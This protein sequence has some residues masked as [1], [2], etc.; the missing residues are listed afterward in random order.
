MLEVAWEEPGLSVPPRYSRGHRILV[1][2]QPLPTAS[3][4]RQRIPLDERRDQVGFIDTKHPGA[5]RDPSASATHL[6]HHYLALSPSARLGDAGLV[7]LA[8]MMARSES[9][10]ARPAL[11]RL[12]ERVASEEW[13]L[14]PKARL[15]IVMALQRD[16]APGLVRDLLRWMDEARPID[17]LE[18]ISWALEKSGQGDAIRPLESARAA[19]TGRLEPDREGMLL[20]S[21][22]VEERVLAC[23]YLQGDAARRRLPGLILS[24]PSPRVR[25]VALRRW[26]G[27]EGQ[28]AIP[29]VVRALDD[30]SSQV[31]RAAA[32]LL[33]G[34]GEPAIDDLHRLTRRDASEGAR[35]AV[36]SL[37]MMGRP[38]QGA[39]EDVAVDHE[40]EAMRTLARMALGLPIGHQH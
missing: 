9:A 10:L 38:A 26:V 29:E 13:A 6:I 35:M 15:E 12:D 22:V 34:L 33:V 21:E 5:I 7:R 14:P 31:R 19:I 32:E 17:L 2:L 20:A 27:L 11:A 1:G 16:D 18:P 37:S 30:S 24:D 4:W 8:Q 25:T 23:R 36:A 39:L 40:D 3:I 28:A